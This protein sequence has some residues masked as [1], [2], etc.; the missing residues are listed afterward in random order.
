M[1]PDAEAV[2]NTYLAEALG[3]DIGTST[4][5]DLSEPWVRTTLIVGSKEPK[6]TPAH[7]IP[8]HLQ[9]DCFAGEGRNRRAEASD[10]ARELWAALEVVPATRGETTINGA[11]LIGIKPMPDTSIEPARERFIVEATVWMHG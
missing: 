11:S 3:I 10:L 8:F 9:F 7:L 5:T 1:I 6:S 4:P 2:V